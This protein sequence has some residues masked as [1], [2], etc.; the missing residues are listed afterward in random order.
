MIFAKACVFLGK[1]RDFQKC[2]KMQHLP[3]WQR[4]LPAVA[5]EGRGREQPR[6]HSGLRRVL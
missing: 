4:V 6:K 2:S 3:K 1:Y 5:T